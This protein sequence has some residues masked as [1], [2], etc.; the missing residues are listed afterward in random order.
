MF[1]WA[2]MHCISWNAMSVLVFTF[3][4]LTVVVVTDSSC[5]FFAFFA[6]PD[7]SQPQPQKFS[8]SQSEARFSCLSFCVDQWEA[9]ILAVILCW[10]IRVEDSTMTLQLH[11]TH[12]QCTLTASYR[13]KNALNIN[14]IHFKF[15]FHRQFLKNY[16]HETFF[17]NYTL[18]F[19]V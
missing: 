2:R 8:V 3:L 6:L 7:P 4:H 1:S 12:T 13:R 16:S 19:R 9:S 10:P 17:L 15:T 14:K 5:C 18:L 11:H